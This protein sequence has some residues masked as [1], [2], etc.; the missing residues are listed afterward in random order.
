M[1]KFKIAKDDLYHNTRLVLFP[2]DII[3]KL[4]PWPICNGLNEQQYIN[5]TKER[6]NKDAHET[7]YY[8]FDGV[9][10]WK[11]DGGCVMIPQCP[12]EGC[13]RYAC[14][15]HLNT[16]KKNQLKPTKRYLHHTCGY[17][18]ETQV[19]LLSSQQGIVHSWLKTQSM[20][21]MKNDINQDQLVDDVVKQIVNVQQM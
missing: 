8:G 10:D 20:D 1:P 7:W 6:T 16:V 4:T 14:Q 5:W 19:A 17:N 15:T 21:Q 11:T 18:K 2:H 9:P 3:E 12:Q 13:N